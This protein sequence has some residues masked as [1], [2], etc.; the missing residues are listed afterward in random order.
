VV[1][2]AYPNVR[3]VSLCVGESVVFISARWVYLPYD[4]LERV[5]NRIINE[6]SG[7]SRVAYDVSSKPPGTI[8][9]E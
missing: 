8:E 3:A 4:L 9:W 6:T 2:E 1:P 7:I 5:S